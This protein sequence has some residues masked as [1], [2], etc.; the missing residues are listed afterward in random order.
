MAV[1]SYLRDAHGLPDRWQ[2]VEGTRDFR[3]KRVTDF[4]NPLGKFIDKQS[5]LSVAPS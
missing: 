5:D 1:P 2:C 3:S 4:P